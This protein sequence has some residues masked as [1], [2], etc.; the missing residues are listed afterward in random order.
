M[1]G[2]YLY[3]NCEQVVVQSLDSCLAI[4]T[5]AK[6]IIISGMKVVTPWFN[7]STSLLRFVF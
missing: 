4:Y 7:P 5:K 1:Q 6:D 2:V 3:K